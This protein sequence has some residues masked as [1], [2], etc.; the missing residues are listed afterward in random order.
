MPRGKTF[1]NVTQSI[2][3]TP[4]I[5]INR[6]IPDDHATVFAKCEF[7]QPFK[8]RQRSY[9]RGNDRGGRTRRGV[10]RRIARGGTDKRQHRHRIGLRVRCKG[11]SFDADDAR[12]HVARTSRAAACSRSRPRADPCRRRHEGCDRRGSRNINERPKWLDAATVRESREPRHPR[13]HHGPGD[14]GRFG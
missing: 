9:R 3:D 11:L 4:M 14:M 2:G 7:F 1:D 13:I 12:V 10:D 5:K 8:Q 6:L